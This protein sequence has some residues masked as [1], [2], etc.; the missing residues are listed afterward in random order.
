M[1][2][3]IASCP[4]LFGIGTQRTVGEIAIYTP[5]AV[6]EAEFLCRVEFS[7]VE[8]YTREVRGSDGIHAL[9]CALAYLNGITANSK[10]PE[11]FWM[12]GDTM[13]IDRKD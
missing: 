7:G 2:K 11:F 3:A 13:F 8:K 6:D 1:T 10:D 4:V 9:D 5:E 12:N